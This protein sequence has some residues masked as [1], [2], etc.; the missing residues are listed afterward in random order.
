MGSRFSVKLGFFAKRCV[1]DIVPGMPD[2]AFYGYISTGVAM[3]SHGACYVAQFDSSAAGRARIIAYVDLF[4]RAYA[5]DAPLS[6]EPKIE[7]TMVLYSADDQSE[8]AASGLSEA[9]GID[10]F[11]ESGER[12][13]AAEVTVSGIEN[14]R[15][16]LF[17][18][19][20]VDS[21]F[22]GDFRVKTQADYFEFMATAYLA[23]VEFGHFREPL[24]GN[25]SGTFDLEAIY[26]R[27]SNF[28]LFDAVNHE[29]LEAENS[30]SENPANARGIERYLVHMLHESGIVG[31]SADDLC[32][33]GAISGPNARLIRT[34]R[35]ADMFYVDFYFNTASECIEDGAFTTSE[36]TREARRKLL[37]AESALNR[38]R[39]IAWYLEGVGEGNFDDSE[40]SISDYDASYAELICM[41][42]PDP[43]DPADVFGRWDTHLAI[44]RSGELWRLP[45]RVSYEFCL[46]EGCDAVA[47]NLAVPDKGVMAQTTWDA[48]ANRYVAIDERKGNDLETRYAGHAALLAAACAFHASPQVSTVCVNCL[49]GGSKDDVV[50]SVR[51]DRERFCI[52]YASEDGHSFSSPRDTLGVFDARFE[53]SDLGRLQAVD[54]LFSMGEGEFETS[55]EPTIAHD[56]AHL[57][58]AA[59]E[60]LGVDC[61]MDMNIFEDAQRRVFADEVIDALD[62]GADSALEK[63]KCIHDRSEDLLVRGICS[64]LA[65]DFSEHGC[66]DASFIEV[67]E[68][69]ID[70]YG[71]RA[72]ALRASALVRDNDPSAIG[73]LEDLAALGDSL[74]GFSDSSRACY[75]YFDGYESRAMY[76]RYC[77][78]DASGRKV[79]PL[80][81]EVFLAHDSLA[82]ELT[83]TI[84]GADEALAHAKRC[85]ELA[86]SRAYSYLR[87]ARVYFV[88]NDFESEAEMCCEALRV[89]WNANDTS[90]A[91]YWLAYSFWKREKYDAA[92]ACYR[93][94]ASMGSYMSEEANTELSELTASVK[95]LKKRTP[96]EENDILV[97]EGVPI[98][99]L[100]GN[101]EFMLEAAKAC[102]D[103]SAVSLGCTLAGS[104][105]RVLRDD[106]VIPALRALR[107]GMK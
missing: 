56:C 22:E 79:L 21:S 61:A 94:V 15:S 1:V 23:F 7:A 105:A 59:Q 5:C 101:A 46:N 74:E 100:E 86:P 80:P 47:F 85:I 63:L 37:R 10:V 57:D 65:E 12:R 4:G 92:V 77:A 9:A 106:A 26:Q 29:V 45:Y 97:A 58:D 64:R 103:S 16:A 68:A 90:L 18:Y 71:L 73:I 83:S 104:A 55:F 76:S 81:D 13:H 11:S 31:L 28:D 82:Q 98:D 24:G 78:A 70:A 36:K 54:P 25:P 52:A 3:P 34:A 33:P 53:I 32:L 30:W 75:R 91:L 17:E 39:L 60:L 66:S 48:D 38:F 88:K 72:L 50:I 93:R 8:G 89:S 27:F 62:N 43:S 35:Y 95:G 2:G 69:F 20:T 44:S 96:K 41:Q 42:A 40:A 67:K 107:S 102:V 87:A 51:F 99:A 49:R 6:E 14:V 19:K 84:A